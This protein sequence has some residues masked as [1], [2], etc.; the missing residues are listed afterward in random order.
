MSRVTVGAEG[1]VGAVGAKGVK[2][3]VGAKGAVS[4]SEPSSDSCLS[5][6]LSVFL[7]EFLS[8]LFDIF[9]SLVIVFFCSQRPPN[10]YAMPRAILANAAR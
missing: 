5:K 1:A 4:F 9:L 8:M 2:S 7:S 10:F 3:A 6:F